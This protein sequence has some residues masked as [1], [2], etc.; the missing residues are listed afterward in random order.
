MQ[1]L[2]SQVFLHIGASAHLQVSSPHSGG[3]TRPEHI[4]KAILTSHPSKK[5]QG[6][7]LPED[8]RTNTAVIISYCPMN[9]SFIRERQWY[10]T[11]VTAGPLSTHHMIL[12]AI[13]M[14]KNIFSSAGWVRTQDELLPAMPKIST[15]KEVHTISHLPF[16][17]ANW[18]CLPSGWHFNNRNLAQCSIIWALSF[19]ASMTRRPILSTAFLSHH[20]CQR[21]PDETL[22]LTC[23]HWS[24]KWEM[25]CPNMN[26]LRRKCF[27]FLKIGKPVKGRWILPSGIT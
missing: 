25:C 19:C 6:S 3:K 18:R 15:D 16:L 22:T 12:F 24:D 17:A 1:R 27:S 14:W 23:S 4:C 2:C 10:N 11:V 21:Q 7:K 13:L 8:Q 5:L 26:A 20:A 9:T